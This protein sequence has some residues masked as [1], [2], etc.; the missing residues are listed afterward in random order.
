MLSS[1]QRYCTNCGAANQPRAAF[2][3]ACGQSLQALMA[4][5]APLSSVALG[6]LAPS[7]LLKE[8]YR[9]VAQIG[10]GGMGTVYKAEDTLF[11][12]NLVAV[13]RCVARTGRRAASV[14][15]LA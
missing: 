8:R 1:L 2:C 6:S 15:L 5:T 9:I 11:G 7:H 12:D 14:F 10:K 4:D 13:P 3:F